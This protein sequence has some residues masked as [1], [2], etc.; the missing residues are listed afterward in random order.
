MNR[1]ISLLKAGFFCVL[2][3]SSIGW[4]AQTEIPFT[5]V[6]RF[7]LAGRLLGTIAPDPDGSGPLEYPAV[8]NTYN[9]RG[10]LTKRETGALSDW[11]DETIRPADWP[12]Y[13]S[14]TVHLTKN[15]EYNAY[16]QKIKESVAG[17]NGSAESLV[18]YSYDAKGRVHCKAVRMNKNA[19]GSLPAD[20]CQQSA[21]GI[22]GPDRISRYTYDGLDNVTKEERGLGTPLVQNYKIATFT[23]FKPLTVIDA[24]GNKTEFRY[25][26]YRLVRIVYPSKITPGLLNELDYSQFTYDANSN[27]QTERK[28]NGKIITNTY[29][30]NNRLIKKDFTDNAYSADIFYS[31]DLRGLTLHS[32]FTSDTG[33]GVVNI[34]DGFGNLTRSTNNTGGT[35]R[36]LNYR[37]DENGN[38]VRITHPDSWFFAYGFDGLNRVNSLGESASASSTASTNSLQT[39]SYAANGSRYQIVRTGGTTTTYNRDN[40]LRLGSFVQNF[41]GTTHDLTNTFTY[42]PASQITQLIQSNSFYTYSGNQQ[43]TGSYVVNGLNQYINI[44]GQAVPYD[45]NGNLTQHAGTTYIYDDEN[46]LVGTSGSVVSSLKYDPLGRLF[47]TTIAGAK[48]QFLYS[49]DALVAEYDSSGIITRRYV[50]GDQVDEPWLQYNGNLVGAAYRRF[51]H[52]DH[53]GSII[54]HSSNSG[55]VLSSLAYDAY[56]IPKEAN[57]DRFGYTGQMWLKELGLFHY[58]ARIYS[59]KLGRFL[60]TDPVGYE[61]QMNLYAYAGND[62]VNNVDPTGMTNCPNGDPNCFQTPESAEEVGPPAPKTDEQQKIEEVV[63]TG[64]REKNPKVKFDT[65]EEFFFVAD[66][67]SMKPQEFKTKEIKCGRN[68]MTMGIGQIAPGQAAV[69]SHSNSH[70]SVPSH[71]DGSAARKGTTGMA[72]M[73]TSSRVFSIEAM[74]NGSFRTTLASG[75]AL[76]G[77]ESAALIKNM[78]NWENPNST[79]GTKS[80]PCP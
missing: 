40:A 28:R 34:F 68:R 1:N 63:V 42:S 13:A 77:G 73:M 48:T 67:N 58:K 3:L 55:A 46:R 2:L 32:R 41:G 60:Q 47:E 29:D 18:Q 8:R 20:A 37:Y 21:A 10:L 43:L 38:R 26:K 54:A 36:T 49:G 59:P 31:Y 15:F 61:D 5:T 69:H 14:F 71:G 33:Q 22:E 9:S 35:S 39:I 51:L 23:G 11:L 25:D 56:G 62:P 6:S 65:G 72:F 12:S 4:A 52:A 79:K 17:Q 76:S 16:G 19:Y 30:N 50:H 80:D 45:S 64:H 27:V 57:I 24:N 70:Q 78:Q 44:A 66:T 75:P 74:S 7:D 53:Q